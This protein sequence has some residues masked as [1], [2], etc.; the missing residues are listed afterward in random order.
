MTY[1]SAFSGLSDGS[2]RSGMAVQPMI[3]RRRPGDLG[4]VI[5][6]F[7]NSP[8]IAES[9]QFG[10]TR[11]DAHRTPPVR[12]KGRAPPRPR[13]RV[14]FLE[15]GPPAKARPDAVTIRNAEGGDH[16]Q[17]PG[18]R[19]GDDRGQPGLAARPD[20]LRR[21]WTAHLGRRVPR[22]HPTRARA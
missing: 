13:P 2:R 21:G 9:C 7:I 1:S 3:R 4:L 5:A 15:R 22:R 19:E 18:P 20:R 16:A 14:R 17:R 8:T 11:A 6:G 10:Y 12:G